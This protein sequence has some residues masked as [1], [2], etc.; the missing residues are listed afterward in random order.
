MPTIDEL[1][2]AVSVSD[3]DELVV[4]Q[5]DTARKATRAQLLAGVQ[6]ALA[7][8]SGTLLGRVSAG[9]GAPET[10]ALGANLTVGNGAISAPAPFVIDALPAGG[11]P[12]AADQVPIGQG[13][14]NAAIPYATFMGGLSGISGIDGSN[15]T[16]ATT[17]AGL[18]RRLADSMADA[19][20]IES[21]GAVGDGVTDDAAAFTAALA[22]GR[23]VRLDGRIYVVNGVLAVAASTAMQGIAGATIIRRLQLTAPT[24]WITITAPAFQA[25]GIIFDAGSLAGSDAPAVS[26]SATCM[27]AQFTGCG[28]A[29]AQGATLGSGLSVA[30]AAGSACGVSAC[31]FDGNM[32][33]GVYATGGGSVTIEACQASA[34]GGCGIRVDPGVACMVQDNGCAGNGE[35]ISIGAWSAGPATPQ[36]GPGCMVTGNVCSGSAGWGIAVAATGA[37]IV[38]NTVTASGAAVQ[39]GILARLGAS[40]LADNIVNGGGTGIDARGSWGSMIAGNHVAGAATGVMAG[41]SQNL[42]VSGNVLLMNGW[43]LRI[44]AIEPVLSFLP[45]GPLT[46]S[47]NW[48]GFTT[49]QGGGICVLDGA[50]GVAVVDNDINGWGSA[51]VDQALWLHTDC[52]VLRGNRWNNQTHFRV[53][54]NTVAGL[55]ALIVPDMA[56]DV[57][58]TSAAS[59]VTSV[60]TAHQADTLGQIAFIKVSNGGA[61]YTTAQVTI[62]GS[63]TGATANAVVGN[64]Q[65]LWIVVSNPGSGYGLIGSAAPVT[66]TGD[67]A[68]A[69]AQAFVG[70]PVLDGKRLR[71]SCNC[72]LQLALAGSSPAQQ[73]WT[74]FEST[75][76][77]Y[78]AM[79][80]EGAFG[81]WRAVAFPPVDYLAPTGDGGVVLQ[82]VSGGALTLRPG[83][84]GTLHLASAVEAVGCTSSVGRGSPLGMVSAPPGSDFRNLNGGAGNTFWV[85]QANSDATGW[86][87]IG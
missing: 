62:G 4:S 53:Q 63:G 10:L 36:A 77:A 58:V 13:G 19:L 44:S 67:G 45:T 65:V 61:G 75:V 59:P 60:M 35:G 24:G 76:P 15:V 11:A 68:G 28:F 8:P 9:I 48:I 73:S 21:F 69:V 41:G 7:I 84:G 57:L 12:G 18:P 22:S 80:L 25:S 70:L 5:A 64:G 54:A 74:G 39:G 49:A 17:G 1:P 50:Q 81:A 38:G 3:T 78:G 40:R 31:S 32:L 2:P 52:G 30:G 72:Q 86:V 27:D 66:I 47:A 23:P 29:N 71:L 34:N 82:S 51:T 33:H 55:Q 43:A 79:E 42:V 85:K 56:E 83:S 20:S 26:V 87:A 46:I 14:Q 37:L 16:V 6:P